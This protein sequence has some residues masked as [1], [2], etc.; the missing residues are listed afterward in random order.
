[1]KGTIAA[2][3]NKNDKA[4]KDSAFKNNAEENQKHISKINNTLIE[5]VEDLSTVRP[6]YILL[7]YSDNYSMPSGSLWDYYR[8]KKDNLYDNA[9]QDK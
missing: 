7:K 2:A 4:P 5:N 6:M 1:M 9:S 8:V 3:A